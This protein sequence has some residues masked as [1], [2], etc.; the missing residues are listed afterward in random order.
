L[1]QVALTECRDYDSRKV[2]DAVRKS[3]DLLGGMKKFAGK[4][5]RIL[6]KPNLLAPYAAD[7]AVLTH[8]SVVEAVC[9][10]VL[11]TGAT[12]VVGDSGAVGTARFVA[13]RSGLLPYLEKTGI[14][15]IDFKK[16]REFENPH[17]INFKKFELAEEVISADAVINV[18]K[19][20]TH[21]QV[22]MTMA[23][24]NLFGAIIGMRKSQW[25]M[26]AGQDSR[27]FAR[28]LV[29]LCYFIK[30]ELSIVD[31][32]IGMEGNGPSSGTPRKIG[33]IAAGV[34]PV[35]TEIVGL[36]A[37]QV[38]TLLAAE[39]LGY[40]ITDLE[41]IEILGE[42]P[43]VFRIDNFKLPR[44][45]SD[46]NKSNMIGGLFRSAMT[47]KPVINHTLCN[48]CLT[49]VKHCP[50]EAMDLPQD[51][52]SSNNHPQVNIDYDKCIRCFC[53]QELCPEG[54]ITIRDGWGLKVMSLFRR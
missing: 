46:G 52:G 23:V 44:L 1:T 22:M 49:C 5:Q 48:L 19:L 33:L 24:K 31:G 40:G 29:E 2:S 38:L 35:L 9:D 18:A 30:P 36:K 13:K 32:V 43:D 34:D 4:G 54:A 45:A 51:R 3:V 17:G 47:S 25:H 28:M 11:E 39:D 7:R 20:K 10:L 53:C 14:E 12:P 6:V 41:Q 26:R 8:H 27:Y 50:P 16:S 37:E 42:N 15:L 21:G